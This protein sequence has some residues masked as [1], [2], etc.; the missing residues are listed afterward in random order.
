[1]THRMPARST[2]APL[3]LVAAAALSLGG[4]VIPD[5]D[6]GMAITDSEST[7]SQGTTDGSDDGLDD[8]ASDGMD[9]TGPAPS[10]C[11]EDEI[12]ATVV[13]HSGTISDEHWGLGIHR[14]SGVLSIEGPVTVE[15]CSI[16]EMEDG[17][18]IMVTNGG[19][20]QMPGTATQPITV[21]S[22]KSSPEPGDWDHIRFRSD[23]VGPDNLL[24][25]VIIEYGGGSNYYGAV[26]LNDGGSVE[27]HD[28]TVRHSS[29]FGMVL[30]AD[31]ELRNFVGNTLVDNATGAIELPANAAGN[32]GEGTYSPNEV[33]GIF[34]ASGDVAHDQTWLNHD[35][36]YVA[37]GGF[38]V[39][40]DTGS[41][42]L[43]VAAGAEI[44]MG[45]NTRIL[46]QQLGGLT[47]DGTADAPVHIRS[48]KSTGAAGDWEEIRIYETSVD[49]FN[50]F[51]HVLIEHGGAG[52]YGSVWVRSEAS[53]Q[54][55]N[56]TIRDSED[57]AL[58]VDNGGELRQFAD[59]TL[60]ENGGAALSIGANEV[61]ELGVGNYSGNGVE[62]IIVRSATV[63]HDAQWL[64]HGV[65]YL[66]SG[67]TVGDGTGSAVLTLD[68]GSELLFG[69]SVE[70]FIS[71]NG[72][73]TA[74]GT[75]DN[76]VRI[77]SDK[78]SPAAG[79]WDEIRVESGSIDA[80]NVL[81]YTD[82]E[83]GGGNFYGML[84][85]RAEAGISLDNVTF[86]EPGGG[87]DVRADG[88]V[89]ATASPYIPCR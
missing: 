84:W 49:E 88:T 58:L 38:V 72:A 2:H 31:S 79:D 71:A 15:P 21:T 85:V 7:T 17:A 87:C 34:L 47:L 5:D 78:A 36:P 81:R 83:Y 45:D 26:N 25:H 30:A 64:D 59:N 86:S 4:C 69:D 46:V 39:D 41:A 73:L 76:H 27:M 37:P 33:E 42:H 12:S 57:F 61:G 67:F 14:V 6:E 52:Y 75:A 20:L 16:V 80:S 62:G 35:A 44:R 1:M 3:L 70:M 65:P 51:S 50:R 74:N 19:S 18:L 28:C 53:L 66:A 11:D 68:A 60:T 48:A 22:A 63:D 9:S 40:T 8:T 54:M 13:E 77:G 89:G 32:L 10:M 82:I 55:D 56:T 29:N 24:E 43:T 23:S